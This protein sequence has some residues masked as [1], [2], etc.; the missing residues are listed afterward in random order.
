CVCCCFLGP[1]PSGAC[2]AVCGGLTF[3]FFF[4][5]WFDGRVKD[6]TDIGDE[7][8]VHLCAQLFGQVFQQIV[9]VLFGQDDGADTGTVGGQN[10]F[11]DTSNGHDFAAQGD[12]TSHGD[13]GTDVATTC[14][15]DQHGN[16]GDA[17]R[18][19]IFGNS[20]GGY[21]DV[22]VLIFKDIVWQAQGDGVGT[23]IAES[24]RR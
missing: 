22:D 13:I 11:F 5:D 9:L 10:L 6:F 14:Q 17:C 23:Y 7:D 16:H 21:M 12:L 8:E 18:R 19:T 2:V 20:S 24:C 15:R 4:L 3:G 1:A